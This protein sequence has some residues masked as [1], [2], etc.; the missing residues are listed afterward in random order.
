VALSEECTVF[1]IA[2]DALQFVTCFVNVWNAHDETHFYGVLK[3]QS[4]YPPNTR[5]V[6]PVALFSALH[7]ALV[8]RTKDTWFVLRFRSTAIAEP[9][10]VRD[11]LNSVTSLWKLIRRLHVELQWRCEC[12]N[13]MHTNVAAIA[14]NHFVSVFSELAAKK[15]IK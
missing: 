11:F 2:E 13:L 15:N 1:S 7:C 12:A 5:A 9:I 10:T 4:R 8:D 14:K 6:A 3:M